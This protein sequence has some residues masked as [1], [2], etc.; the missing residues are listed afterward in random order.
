MSG[1]QRAMREQARRGIERAT[2]VPDHSET[3]LFAHINRP[4]VAKM[5]Y[6]FP[7]PFTEKPA[8]THGNELDDVPLRLTNPPKVSATVY[9]WVTIKEAG[10]DVVWTGAKIVF[11]CEGA[12]YYKF[13]VPCKFTGTGLSNPTNGL[14][15]IESL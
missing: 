13:I 1:L 4:G 10:V 11:V 6:E 7:H 9:S 8:F 12:S 2:Y 3:V 15:S 14:Y 5:T